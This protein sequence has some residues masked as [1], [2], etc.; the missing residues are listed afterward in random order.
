MM[1]ER[2]QLKFPS[3]LFQFLDSYFELE[4]IPDRLENTLN[5]LSVTEQQFRDPNFFFDGDQLFLMLNLL[6]KGS[7][8]E[9][10]AFRILRYQSL[11]NM[12][13][14]GIAGLTALTLKDAL[15]ITLKVHR[16]LMPAAE[17][18]FKENNGGFELEAV[19]NADFEHCGPIL[20][21]IILGAL[22]KFS[23][24]VT[25][26][27]AKLKLAFAHPPNWGDDSEKTTQLYRDFFGCEVQFNA[28]TSCLIANVE[29]LDKRL[30]SP[31]KIMYSFA[32]DILDKELEKS[33]HPSSFADKAKGLL[34]ESVN[35]DAPFSLEELALKLNMTSR[36]LSRK[37]AKENVQ[38]KTLLNE[39]RFERAKF[40]LNKTDAPIKQLASKLG[41]SNTDAFSRAFKTYTGM[42]PNQWK[43]S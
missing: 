35:N 25:G 33:N 26:E 42:T 7:I 18:K 37:L 8:S 24:E 4:H 29:E 32:A 6:E 12:G 28:P 22:K 5:Y 30:K 21:E 14:A 11:S 31:N 36:T 41:F 40:L 10:P 34:V 43:M 1:G 20:T 17:L 38:Y 27:N 2:K 16:A 13:M 39:V 23:D 3:V 9:P 19:L 15:H